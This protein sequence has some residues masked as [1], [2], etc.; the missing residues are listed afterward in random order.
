MFRK[1]TVAYNGSPEAARALSQAIHLAKA[2]GAE[3]RAITV[4]QDLPPYTAYATPADSSLFRELIEDQQAHCA[5]LHSEARNTALREG[6][7]LETHLL[8]GNAVDVIVRFLLD[9]ETDLLVIGLHRHASH[10]SR[11]WSTVYEVA[12]DAQCSV[13]GVH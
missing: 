8:E 2:L 5:R 1:I 10:I 13:L 7:K 3:L 4:R 12:V 11:I 6:V 9:N